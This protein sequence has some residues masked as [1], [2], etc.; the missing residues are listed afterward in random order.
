M[1]CSALQVEAKVKKKNMDV[2]LWDCTTVEQCDIVR[3]LSAGTVKPAEIYTGCWLSICLYRNWKSQSTAKEEKRCRKQ[4]C[5]I[6]TMHVPMQWPQQGRQWN[7]CSLNIFLVSLT[8]P[9]LM[10]CSC[11]ILVRLKR[12]YAVKGSPLRMRLRKTCRP[13]FRSSWKVSSPN[14]WIR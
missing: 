2:L 5:S 8:V 6:M 13:G 11:H 12:L 4:S 10:P 14:E 1:Q 7:I 9:D 3:F